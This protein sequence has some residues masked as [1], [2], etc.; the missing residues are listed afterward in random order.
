V[1]ATGAAKTLLVALFLCAIPA[2]A[3][4]VTPSGSLPAIPNVSNSGSVPWSI[5]ILLTL[6]TLIPTVLLSMTPFVRL[7]VVFHFLRQ[8]LGTQTTPSNQTLIGLAL[9]LSWLLLQPTTAA[10]QQ[11]AIVPFQ[12][13][14]VSAL[15]AVELGAQPLKRFMLHYV[16]EKDVALFVEFS[17]Q[18]RPNRA[19]DLPMSIV[20]PAYL[21]SELKAG[22]QI[23]AILFLPFLVVDLVVAAVTTS[24]GMLQTAGGYLNTSENYGYTRRRAVITEERP[25]YEGNV[26]LG[27]GATLASIQSVRDRVLELRISAE[28]QQQ[29]ASQS[30]INSMS[31]VETLFGFGT[32]SLGSQVQDFFN[33]LSELSSSPTDSSLRQGVLIAAQN[34][35]RTFH[36]IAGGIQTQSTQIDQ[37]V[38]QSVNE[39]NR[40]TQAIADINQQVAARSA[41]GQ[42]SGTLEDQR[43]TLISQLSSKIDLFVTDSSDG[44]TLTTVHGEPLVVAGKS[45]SISSTSDGATGA[46]HIYAGSLDITN[47]LHGGEL[48]GLVQARDQQLATLSQSLDQFAYSFATALNQA[49]QAGFDLSGNAGVDLFAIGTSASGAASR[50][51]VALNDPSLLAASSDT[52]TGGNGNL[53]AMVD[54]QKQRIIAGQLPGE[55]YSNLVFKV[56]G[57]IADAKA[58]QSA[59]EVVLNQLNDLRGSISG[60]SLDEESANLVRFQQAYQASARVIQAIN[61]MLSTAVNLGRS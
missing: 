55:A 45:Y 60:V 58:D 6:L 41:L 33:S 14:R 56:G 43:T 7:L 19:D 9:V 26:I 30:F 10:I 47:D 42:E 12:Q 1:S 31:T 59:G 50:I 53:L 21:L 29:S 20:A 16:R 61:E 25:F 3:G 51:T 4:R 22:F 28:Q 36:N 49:H 48:G 24:I 23:G 52:A 57:A 44:L 34:V 2:F 5:V 40:L 11:Q 39:V 32:D 35:A 17:K 38:T 54:L 27:R 8:A 18:A 46:Q 37:S 13:H 15:E